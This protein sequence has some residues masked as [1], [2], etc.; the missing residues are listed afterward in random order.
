M[1]RQ[2]LDTRITLH[3]QTAQSAPTTPR[4]PMSTVNSQHVVHVGRGEHGAA[5]GLR[6][7]FP[8]PLATAGTA[9]TAGTGSCAVRDVELRGSRKEEERDSLRHMGSMSVMSSWWSA[10][11]AG[12]SAG[13][14]EHDP[15][16]EFQQSIGSLR[17]AHAGAPGGGELRPQPDS[18]TLKGLFSQYTSL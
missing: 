5:Q 18:P 3:T 4:R 2:P 6:G 17:G 8:P 13:K 1:S 10:E 11:E 15:W 14:Q 9:G 16:L 7:L 12:D